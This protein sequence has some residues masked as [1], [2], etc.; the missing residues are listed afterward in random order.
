MI[1][2]CR[3][4]EFET[5]LDIINLAAQSYKGTIPIDCW[6][7]PYMSKFE[8]QGEIKSGVIFWG[9][10]QNN[11]LTGVMGNQD[12]QDVTLIRHAYVHPD[13]QG[14]GI[15]SKLLVALEQQTSRPVLVGTWAAATWAIRFYEKNGFRLVTKVKKDQLLR[16]Y[17]SIPDRQIETSVVLADEKWFNCGN[18]S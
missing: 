1:R 12:I 18:E 2:P 9:F 16:K 14:Q 8:L 5:I 17:W 11:A 10:E 6:Q 15:G 13:S 3:K 7:D 4:D